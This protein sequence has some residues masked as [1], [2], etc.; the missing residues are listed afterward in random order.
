MKK[1]QIEQFLFDYAQYTVADSNGN[2][3]L[4]KIDYT[5]NSF[6]VTSSDKK[7]RKSFKAEIAE[8]ARHLLQRKHGVNRAAFLDK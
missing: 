1:R 4:L 6:I 2:I 3:V 8:V 5:N 7:V